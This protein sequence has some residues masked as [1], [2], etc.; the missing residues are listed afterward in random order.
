MQ[1]GYY[2]ATSGGPERQQEIYKEWR[3]QWIDEGMPWNG[4]GQSPPPDWDPAEQLKRLETG[5]ADRR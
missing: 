1:F 2:D 5:A 4:E 3:E